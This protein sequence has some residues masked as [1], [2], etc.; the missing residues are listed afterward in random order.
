M[1]N[2]PWLICGSAVRD[3]GDDNHSNDFGAQRD[4]VQ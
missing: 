3:G 4:E 2:N 1:A